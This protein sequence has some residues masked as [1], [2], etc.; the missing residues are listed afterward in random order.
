MRLILLGPPGSGKGTQ[1][2]LL[3]DQFGIPSISTGSILRAAIADKSVLGLQAQSSMDS[4]ELAPDNIVI[5]V[6]EKRLAEDDCKKGY[7]LDGFPR[8]LK[9][10]QALDG[11]LASANRHLDGVVNLVVDDE[12]V[13]RRL[14][15]RRLCRQCGAGFHVRYSPPKNKGFC[16]RCGGELYQR[17][18]DEE[19]TIR[20]RLQVYRRQTE[21]LTDY[22]S[23][24]GLLKNMTAKGNPGEIFEQIA[25]VLGV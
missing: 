25:K 3:Q 9:Q 11:L 15:G 18:D 12:E 19:A 24:K 21:P 8:T 20:N 16:D 4:G 1:G 2:S 5:Q 13:L 23:A 7:I 10:A 6:I 22:Y 14:T 17:Q